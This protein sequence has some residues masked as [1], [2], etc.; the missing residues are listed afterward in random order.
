MIEA[1]YKKKGIVI[2]HIWYLNDGDLDEIESQADIIYIHGMKEKFQTKKLTKV[3][4]QISLIS[5]LKEDEEVLEQKISKSYKKEIKRSTKDGMSI[6]YYTSKELKKNDY[7]LQ[8]FKHCYEEMYK[9]KGMNVKFNYELLKKYIEKNAIIVS[10]IENKEKEPV[11]FNSYIVGEYTARALHATSVFRNKKFKAS[12]IARANKYLHWS[13]MKYF[14]EHN[15]STFD[16][17]GISNYDN[18]NGIDQ[19]KLKFGG[20]KIEYKNILI[21]NSIKGKVV[22]KLL[23]LKE[24][25]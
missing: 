25:I 24:R 14:K 10:T 16:W 11:V 19:F 15:I 6:K 21:S 22:I 8:K 12:E 17:G 23:K 1:V 7:I 5:N 20:E 3:S 2:H 13:D 18:P 9:S 4:N